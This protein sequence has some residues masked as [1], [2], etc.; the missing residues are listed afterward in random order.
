MVNAISQEQI[1]LA[2]DIIKTCQQLQP[3]AAEFGSQ[4][5]LTNICNN[6]R[7]RENGTI[8]LRTQYANLQSLNDTARAQTERWS[9]NL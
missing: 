4:E 5:A 7:N 6:A 3:L 2:D 1:F 9:E 8:W